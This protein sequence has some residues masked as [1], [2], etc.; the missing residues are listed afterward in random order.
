MKKHRLI[1]IAL[2]ATVLAAMLAT[3]A[4]AGRCGSGM[5]KQGAA[6]VRAQRMQRGPEFTVEQQEQIQEI[7]KRYDDERVELANRVKVLHGEMRDI[8][9]ADEPDFGAIERKM[10]QISEARLELA[11]LRLRIHKD[12]RPILTEDQRVLFDRCIGGALGHG[13]GGHAAMGCGMMG[14]PGAGPVG[15]RGAGRAGC[16][17]MGGGMGA[18]SPMMGGPGQPGPFCPW[19]P[20]TD[21]ETQ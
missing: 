18:R 12:I 7:H 2:V 19:A 10:E 13:R 15:G 1:T 14:G 17:M 8:I 5:G 6:G 21:E 3:P 4:M 20:G 9:A 11:K 16:G